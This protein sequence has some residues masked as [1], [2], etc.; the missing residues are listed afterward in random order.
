MFG[1]TINSWSRSNIEVEAGVVQLDLRR[2]ERQSERLQR[3]WQKDNG[4]KIAECFQTLK[5]KTEEAQ[6]K[7][8]HHS[9]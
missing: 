5:A 1:D 6:E 9:G 4:Q 2:E 3:S 8:S 7:I